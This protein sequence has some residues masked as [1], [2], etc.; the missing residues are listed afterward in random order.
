MFLDK[1]PRRYYPNRGLA[2]PLI[3]WAGLDARGQE[4]IELAFDRQLRGS[5]R[6]VPGLRDALGRNLLVSGLG[7]G[8]E[9]AGH[10]LYTTIDRYIQYR[11]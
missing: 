10:D 11:V 5:V 1:E 7:D 6:Q 8:G 3:G 4:G 9:E 2:G